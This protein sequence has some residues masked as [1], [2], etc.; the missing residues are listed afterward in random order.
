MGHAQSY[1]YLKEMMA[2]PMGKKEGQHAGPPE[3]VR[4]SHF[5]P[6]S[7]NLQKYKDES[8]RFN[9][10]LVKFS[11]CEAKCCPCLLSRRWI[12]GVA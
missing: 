1:E 4:N 12:Y 2:K 6:G 10:E 8:I 3:V 11:R 7:R 5:G 9:D